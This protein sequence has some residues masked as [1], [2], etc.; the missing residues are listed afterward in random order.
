[1][2]NGDTEFATKTATLTARSKT[3]GGRFGR[4]LRLGIAL[5][6]NDDDRK[7]VIRVRVHIRELVPRLVLQLYR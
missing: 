6:H 3:D 4:A 2:E 5:A 7:G 1:M